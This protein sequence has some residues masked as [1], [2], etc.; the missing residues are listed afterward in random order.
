M[1][2]I[3]T[4]SVWAFVSKVFTST[5]RIWNEDF[6]SVLA[7]ST[8]VIFYASEGTKLDLLYNLV[9]LAHLSRPVLFLRTQVTI[10]RL[11]ELFACVAVALTGYVIFVSRRCDQAPATWQGPGQ[12]YLIPCKTTHR[13]FF[14]EKHSF[15]YSYLMVGIPVGYKG[16]A[17]GMIEIDEQSSSSSGHIHYL[18]KL[19]LQSWYRIQASDH[20]ERGHKGH[21]LREKLDRFLQSEVMISASGDAFLC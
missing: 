17:G 5:D 18:V 10:Q 21:G 2:D 1:D 14:P 16:R 9:V 12:P 8:A 13:R 19:L 20:L 3:H 6:L 4:D 7:L 11:S 15:S